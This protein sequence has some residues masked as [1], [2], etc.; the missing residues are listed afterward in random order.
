VNQDNIV[1]IRCL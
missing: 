1:F